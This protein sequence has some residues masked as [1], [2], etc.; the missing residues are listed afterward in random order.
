MS[1]SKVWEIEIEFRVGGEGWVVKDGE[2][3]V[4]RGIGKIGGWIR[5]EG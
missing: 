2:G 3:R 1:F 5:D 4:V